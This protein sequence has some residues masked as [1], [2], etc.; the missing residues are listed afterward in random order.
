E[1]SRY[2][3]QFWLLAGAYQ[4]PEA[5]FSEREWHT[6]TEDFIL[7]RE[8]G[9]FINLHPMYLY[10]DSEKYDEATGI[11]PDL[12]VINGFERKK[13]GWN[14]KYLPCGASGREFATLDLGDERERNMAEQGLKEILE[15]L[16]VLA[17]EPAAIEGQGA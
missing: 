14:I 11:R 12:Y 5:I 16:G 8:G 13:S 6:D 1:T 7:E 4:D 9:G 17:P 3:H 10:L 15:L 2:S